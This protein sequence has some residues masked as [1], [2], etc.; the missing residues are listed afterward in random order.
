MKNCCLTL[1]SVSGKLFSVCNQEIPISP[2]VRAWRTCFLFVCEELDPYMIFC[3][4]HFQNLP[5]LSKVTEFN[6]DLNTRDRQTSC[7]VCLLKLKEKQHI[8]NAIRS[9]S[10]ASLSQIPVLNFSVCKKGKQKNDTCTL[11][12]NNP[13]VPLH[14]KGLYLYKSSENVYNKL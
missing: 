8:K 9:Q 5:Q 2:V 4:A 3:L 7:N 10:I 1:H 13:K 12:C 14:T 11:D 6:T